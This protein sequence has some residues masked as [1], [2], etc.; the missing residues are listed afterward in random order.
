MYALQVVDY[1]D[2]EQGWYTLEGFQSAEDCV[3]H[4][5]AMVELGRDIE[6]NVI[7]L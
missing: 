5:E 1:T 6:Y 3:K 7:K 2:G 4:G